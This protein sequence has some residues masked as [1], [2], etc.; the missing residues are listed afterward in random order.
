MN[1]AEYLKKGDRI[2]IIST[3]RKISPQE[4]EPAISEFERW[5]LEVVLGDNIYCED[6]QFSGTV[7]QRASD[8]QQMLD[9]DS[10]KAVVCARGGYGTVQI[11]DKI[12]FSKFIKKPKWIVG[13]SD[14]TVLH[15]HIN[16]NF[17]IET[18]H[19][20]MPVNFNENPEKQNEV[21][22][23][24][25]ALFG[26][27]LKYEIEKHKFTTLDKS[28]KSEVVG[29]N[30]SIIYS[31]L[32]STSIINSDKRILFFEELDEY[33][34]H[35]DRMM[36]N[37]ERNGLL[38]K[39]EALLIGGMTDMNDN[40]IPF[41]KNAEEIIFDFVKRHNIPA[42][43]GFPAG[44]LSP[45]NPIILGREITIKPVDSKIIIEQ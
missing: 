42:V 12:D 36:M 24:K 23:L 29:G 8:L 14:V 44:H 19:A 2:A 32:G 20:I 25:N 6:N 45:N 40:N 38:Q 31:L 11:I 21:Q 35:I 3:A 9:D 41:G 28:I 17:N 22:L 37:I 15:S 33:L 4:L 39:P 27:K 1:T 30:L 34:Y 26:E 5:G 10:V 13:Y 7:D 43:F 18:L 16:Q